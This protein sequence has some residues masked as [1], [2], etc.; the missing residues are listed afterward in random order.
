MIGCGVR[1]FFLSAASA[2]ISISV[3][4]RNVHSLHENRRFLAERKN[5]SHAAAAHEDARAS[6]ILMKSKYAPHPLAKAWEVKISV[7][8]KV[9]FGSGKF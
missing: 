4:Y 7:E 3:E 6:K 5:P 1:V 8:S 9:N 2:P